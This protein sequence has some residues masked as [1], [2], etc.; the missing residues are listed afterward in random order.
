ME[1]CREDAPAN[2]QKGEKLL[3]LTLALRVKER[4][5]FILDLV[6]PADK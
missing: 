2:L 5:R 6:E 3:P 4:S 1:D